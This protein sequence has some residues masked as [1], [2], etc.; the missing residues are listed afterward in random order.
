MEIL[1]QLREF[2]VIY[3]ARIVISILAFII[4]YIVIKFL[5]VLT[6]K[7]IE[8]SRFDSS[9]GS[10]LQSLLGL[11]YLFILLMLVLTIAGVPSSYFAGLIIGFG[12]ALGFSLRDQIKTLS[13]G[14]II[15]IAKP[16]KIGDAITVGQYSGTVTEIRLFHILIKTFD[17]LDVIISNGSILSSGITI[18]NAN[19]T[20]RQDITIGVS[21][22]D[23]IKKVKSLLQ[24]IID[25]CD[26]VLK[27]PQPLIA[28][29]EFADSSVNFLVRF[30]VERANFMNAKIEINEQIKLTF[31]KEN[32][33]IP[34]PQRDVYIKSNAG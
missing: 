18:L 31:D 3:G 32:I 20:R 12:T 5:K 15:L 26:L 16:F 13:N 34:Y 25:N 9:I 24:G 17:N 10:F 1:I 2:I 30:W 6:K 7:I 19:D 21:Y 4:G 23:D 22:D 11:V 28:L 33:S 29:N 8:R 27:E 14:I